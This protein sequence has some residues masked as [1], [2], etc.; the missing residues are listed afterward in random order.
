MKHT[1][2]HGADQGFIAGLVFCIGVLGIT[3]DWYF[4]GSIFAIIGILI[5]LE[6]YLQRD[7]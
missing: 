2:A 4:T 6:A 3:I 5:Y 7:E 1:S